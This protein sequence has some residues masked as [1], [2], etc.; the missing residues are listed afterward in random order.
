MTVG[1]FIRARSIYPRTYRTYRF[2]R[3]GADV[4]KNLK[5][6]IRADSFIKIFYALSSAREERLLP[7]HCQNIKSRITALRPF[8]TSNQTLKYGFVCALDACHF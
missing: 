6:T 8:A 5:Q 7:F 3:F 1:I 2:G 4:F